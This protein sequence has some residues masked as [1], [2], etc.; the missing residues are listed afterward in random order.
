METAARLDRVDR[1]MLHR[2]DDVPRL[3]ARDR[4]SAENAG[5]KRVLPEKFEVAPPARVTD[6]VDRA[7][8]QH[9]ET[10]GPGFVRDGRAAAREERRIPGRAHRKA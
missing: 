3:D 6:E 10:L 1:E 5:M 8:Q 7:C 2:G 4:R 9:V